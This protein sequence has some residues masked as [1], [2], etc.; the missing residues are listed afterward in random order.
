M[1]DLDDFKI[2]NDTYGHVYGDK[3]MSLIAETMSKCIRNT[4]YIGRFGGDEFLLICTGT[5]LEEALY[6]AERIRKTI[7]SSIFVLSDEIKVRV[8]T[9]LGVHEYDEND[10]SFTDVVKRAD[11]CLYLAKETRNTVMSK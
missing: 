8:T 5:G 1:M 2:V 6:V 4:D 3:A 10:N 9:S 11:Q 7:Q